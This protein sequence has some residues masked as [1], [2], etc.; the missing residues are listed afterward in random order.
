MMVIPATLS[1]GNDGCS[2]SGG[3][4]EASSLE[5]YS[6]V[7]KGNLKTNPLSGICPHDVQIKKALWRRKS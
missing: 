7:P 3:F 4:W 2:I 1:E 6:G 5:E